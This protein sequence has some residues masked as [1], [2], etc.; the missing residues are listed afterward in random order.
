MSAARERYGVTGRQ[1]PADGDYMADQANW[2]EE[3]FRVGEAE[4]QVIKGGRGKPLLIFH[5]ELGDPGWLTWH[6]ALAAERT[7]WIPQHPGFG[8]SAYVDWIMDMR[9]LAAFYS[10]FA[11]EQN[12]APVD[13]IGFSMGGWLAAEMAAQNVHQFTRMILVGAAGLRPPSGEIM[14]MFTVT[15]RAYLNSNVL[16]P[17]GNP[18]FNK[19]FGGEQTPTQYEAWEDARAEAARIAWKPYMFEQAMPHRLANVVGLPTLLIWGRQDPVV[20]LSA[21]ELYHEKIAGSRLVVFDNC[22]HMPEVEKTEDFVREVRDFL[23]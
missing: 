14:D 21:G 11:R 9:D 6:S 13:V 19:L 12:L 1:R 5:G 4:L 2:T 3:K 10:R 16:D 22:G 15:A 23:R 17:H 8:K 7:L 18:E 20:P